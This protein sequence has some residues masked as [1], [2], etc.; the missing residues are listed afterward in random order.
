M[1]PNI[2]TRP[3]QN[4]FIKQIKDGIHSFDIIKAGKTRGTIMGH[5][6]SSLPISALSTMSEME[7]EDFRDTFRCALTP[8]DLSV[9]YQAC[10]GESSDSS[11]DFPGSGFL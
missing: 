2:N 9:S 11:R 1:A 5:I 7:M 10:F 4:L 8:T 6:F 3:S